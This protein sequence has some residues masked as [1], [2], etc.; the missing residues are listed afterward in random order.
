MANQA[1]SYLDLKLQGKKCDGPLIC[2]KY[3]KT[4]YQEQLTNL[5]SCD[6][7]HRKVESGTHLDLRVRWYPL[8]HKMKFTTC[9][10]WTANVLAYYSLYAYIIVYYTE[11]LSLVANESNKKDGI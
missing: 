1:F 10:P 3:T 4:D 9:A 8:T 6:C 5:Q 2:P 7:V 11:A